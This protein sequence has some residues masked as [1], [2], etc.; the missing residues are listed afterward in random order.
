MLRIGPRNLNVSLNIVDVRETGRI[1]THR[2]V[3]YIRSR[4]YPSTGSKSMRI[5]LRL[6][7]SWFVGAKQ[8]ATDNE[9]IVLRRMAQMNVDRVMAVSES[10]TEPGHFF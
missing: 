6:S 9:R 8:G 7:T 2:A 1:I 4:D 5:Y 10:D 3:C